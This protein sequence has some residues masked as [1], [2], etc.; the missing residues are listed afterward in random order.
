MADN[1]TN[2]NDTLQNIMN[3]FFTQEQLI[4]DALKNEPAPFTFPELQPKTGGGKP[5]T[6]SVK[7]RIL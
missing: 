6:E 1:K 2:L 5:E 7:P 4:K 3:D